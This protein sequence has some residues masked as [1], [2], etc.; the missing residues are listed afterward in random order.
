MTFI[1]DMKQVN[2]VNAMKEL[3]YKFLFLLDHLLLI[4]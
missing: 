2:T 1:I 4:L 3:K